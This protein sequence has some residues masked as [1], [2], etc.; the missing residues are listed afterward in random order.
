LANIFYGEK[1]RNQFPEGLNTP[2]VDVFGMVPP[3]GDV[4]PPE[5]IPHLEE[6]LVGDAQ[7]AIT[8]RD[9]SEFRQCT[10][11]IRKMFQNLQTDDQVE[12]FLS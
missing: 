4:F 5:K 10:Y 1:A 12:T 2:M 6:R 3:M 9:P 8:G 7:Q 11:G